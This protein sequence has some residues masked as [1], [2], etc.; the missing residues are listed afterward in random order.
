MHL[1]I[2]CSHSVIQ[3]ISQL[4]K[5]LCANKYGGNGMI[6]DPSAHLLHMNGLKH[7]V[8]VWS[9]SGNHSMWV[10]SLNHSAQVLHSAPISCDPGFQLTFQIWTDKHDFIL[11]IIDPYPHPQHMKVVEH[12]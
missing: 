7:L 8:Y 12:L 3:E 1:E 9:G 4:L 11:M 6:E 5:S 10:C 2:I